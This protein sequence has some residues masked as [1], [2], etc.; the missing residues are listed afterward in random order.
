MSDR[1]DHWKGRV[2]DE[3]KLDSL[4]TVSYQKVRVSQGLGV[5]VSSE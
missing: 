4:F 5:R 3:L 1:K 2:S